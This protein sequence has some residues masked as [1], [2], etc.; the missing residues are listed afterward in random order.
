MFA[1]WHRSLCRN[2][3]VRTRVN[4]SNPITV[5]SATLF[6]WA[7]ASNPSA[8]HETMEKETEIMNLLKSV[9][10]PVSNRKITSIGCIQ[11]IQI[12]IS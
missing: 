11:V 2:V 5:I 9:V 4:A 10:E 12:L 6:N 7:K 1:S 3:L 8:Q